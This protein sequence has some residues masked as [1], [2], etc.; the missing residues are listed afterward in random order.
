MLSELAVNRLQDWFSWHGFGIYK[1]AWQVSSIPYLL[2]HTGLTHANYCSR[3]EG[4]ATQTASGLDSHSDPKSSVRVGRRIAMAAAAAGE[5]S[6]RAM[7]EAMEPYGVNISHETFRQITLGNRPAS[8]PELSAVAEVAG[9]YL[10]PEVGDAFTWLIR[11]YS[12]NAPTPVGGAIPR[13][14]KPKLAD[15][16]DIKTRRQVAN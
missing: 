7:V 16:I 4:M 9:P 11:G 15:V 13:Y 8:V 12:D 5:L 6:D 3:H 14:L 10:E 1:H 2:S